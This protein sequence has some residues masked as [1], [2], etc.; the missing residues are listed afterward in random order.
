MM[1]VDTRDSANPRCSA[2]AVR[3]T[4]LGKPGGG[5]ARRDGRWAAIPLIVAEGQQA[6]RLTVLTNWPALLS[7]K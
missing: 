3:L 7:G 1:S 2:E 5:S 6:T 4:D